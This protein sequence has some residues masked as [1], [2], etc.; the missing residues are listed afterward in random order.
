MVYV[1]IDSVRLTRQRLELVRHATVSLA[2]SFLKTMS[3][4]IGGRH[5]TGELQILI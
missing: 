2:Y 5:G 4:D 1:N 3:A